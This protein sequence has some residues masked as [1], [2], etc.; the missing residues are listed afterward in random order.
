MSRVTRRSTLLLS[1]LLS[2]WGVSVAPAAAEACEGELRINP[3]ATRTLRLTPVARNERK[4]VDSH[5]IR[6]FGGGRYALVADRRGDAVLSFDVTDPKRMKLLSRVS[7]RHTRGAHYVTVGPEEKHAYTG[8]AGHFTVLDI[9]DPTAI[10]E[11]AAV[12]CTDV[13]NSQEIVV[14]PDNEYAYF[15]ATGADTLFVVDIAAKRSPRVV[16]K[17]AGRGPPH[18]FHSVAHLAMHPSG[19]VLFATSYR[20][21]RLVALDVTTPDRP[22]VL[23]SRGAHLVAPHELVFHEGYLYVGAMYDNGADRPRE[24]GALVVYDAS[25]PASLAY[26]TELRMG[27]DGRR[28]FDMLHGLRLDRERKLLF[29]SSQKGNGRPCTSRNSALSVFDVTDPAAPVWLVSYQSCEWLE[30]AQQ[31]D[32]RGDWLFTANHDVPSVAAF[33]L[34]RE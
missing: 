30:G 3:S 6:L 24:Q 15:A 27:D 7:T 25:D 33:R 22:R 31:V 9:S 19:E 21:H 29:A 8:G 26:E 32:F 10:R 17:V 18:F 23:D 2:L 11:V 28:P 16:G 12:R 34:S 13:G 4:Q 5:G 14:G 1:G 20:D